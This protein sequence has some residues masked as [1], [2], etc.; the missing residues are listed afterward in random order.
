MLTK[1]TMKPT[2]SS[3]TTVQ[4]AFA[5]VPL[6]AQAV[7]DSPIGPLTALATAKGIAGLWFD[8]QTHHPGALDAPIVARLDADVIAPVEQ[9]KQRLEIMETI[10]TAVGDV[11]EQVELGGCWPPTLAVFVRIGATGHGN[12]QFDTRNFNLRSPRC[13][14][15]RRGS[16]CEALRRYSP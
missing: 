2:K 8:D 11:Q 6:V 14:T 1:T 9:L 4:Q 16:H 5:G 10:G 15:M 12:C 3:L 13:R 7:L